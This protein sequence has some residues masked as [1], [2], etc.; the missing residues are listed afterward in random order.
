MLSVYV[1]EDYF[2]YPALGCFSGVV[3]MCYILFDILREVQHLRTCFQGDMYLVYTTN[4]HSFYCPSLKYSPIRMT[5]PAFTNTNL[6]TSCNSSYI[7]N[8]H[9][10]IMG[11]ITDKHT[12]HVTELGLNY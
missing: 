10:L 1:Q 7:F 3:E 4:K 6:P 5:H 11:I 2:I 8:A 12:V 9:I